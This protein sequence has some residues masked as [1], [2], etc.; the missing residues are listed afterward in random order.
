[1]RKTLR[2]LGIDTGYL[3]SMFFI[4]LPAFIIGVTG[5]VLGVGTAVIWIG[6]PI[7]AATLF[8]M[9]GMAAAGRSMLP[10]VLRRELPRPRYK[11]AREDASALRRY[12]TPLTD[13]Q[14]W[15]NVLWAVAILPIAITGFAVAIS[16][17]CATVA[18][19]LYPAY[20][21]II[22][23]A[24]DDSDDGLRYATE[25][26]GWGDSYL[27]QSILAVIGGVFMALTLVPVLR[28]LALAQALVG[29]G[30]LTSIS[31]LHERIDQL[32]ESR[33]AATS[34]EADALRRIERDIHDGPQQRL[35]GL[36]MELARVK[37]QLA[38][39][40][41]AAQ[42][43]LEA[44]IAQT[45][46]TIDELRSLS[47]GIA[48]PILTDRGLAAALAALAARSLVPVELE[49]NLNG[50]YKA[51]VESTVY[52]VTAECLTNIA[53]HSQASKATVAVEDWGDRLV[54]SVGDNGIGGAH[55]SKGHGLSG[56][57]DRVKAV[58]GQW[59]IDSPDGGPT[60]IVVEVPCV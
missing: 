56:L 59:T 25:W 17:W 53:K 7:A 46:E 51:S 52:F 48:P 35:V 58:E 22:R 28:G 3:L 20:S 31:G 14:S 8:A 43:T 36:G 13:G 29:K 1:M 41:E 23:A 49:T 4:A 40:P 32:E 19:L 26:L 16:W 39:N 57:T 54:L 60:V 15:L 5:T 18:A 42:E 27:A 45:R 2:Q 9:R 6:V 33:N 44:A 47:R 24:T 30:M 55:V 50:R 37:R 38:T 10:A 12:L 11:R 21:W 34:A